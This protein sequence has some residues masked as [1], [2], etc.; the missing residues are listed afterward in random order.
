MNSPYPG[1]RIKQSGGVALVQ[2]LEDGME[3]V[4][5]MRIDL[6]K[7]DVEMVQERGLKKDCLVA[8][9]L[10]GLYKLK[11]M[12]ALVVAMA[13]K[14]VVKNSPG[15][16]QHDVCVMDGWGR[17]H[18][19][20]GRAGGGILHRYILA[21]DI[22]CLINRGCALFLHAV[23]MV[24]VI[25]MKGSCCLVYSCSLQPDCITFFSYVYSVDLTPAEML[26]KPA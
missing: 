5:T 11:G 1:V 10:L 16:H 14:E 13:T 7:G 21:R 15:V 26:R 2:P 25:L 23:P 18:V 20:D 8:P 19:D 4:P 9:G 6:V 22:G 12:S 24:C 17:F 3:I